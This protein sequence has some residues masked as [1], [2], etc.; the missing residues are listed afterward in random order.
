M[1]NLY[2]STKKTLF[3]KYVDNYPCLPKDPSYK[4]MRD[5]FLDMAG[6]NLEHMDILPPCTELRP[7]LTV[8]F[9]A[10][11]AEKCPKLVSANFG[12]DVVRKRFAFKYVEITYSRKLTA[13]LVQSFVH[14]TSSS[15]NKIQNQEY[16]YIDY[17]QELGLKGQVTT[18]KQVSQLRCSTI[19]NCEQRNL[20]LDGSELD[21]L[22]E[23]EA[24]MV[25]FLQDQVS[26]EFEF[27]YL[28]NHLGLKR[29]NILNS[30][31]TKYGDYHGMGMIR[32]VRFEFISKLA[33][34]CPDLKHFDINNQ[35]VWHHHDLTQANAR[36]INNIYLTDKVSSLQYVVAIIFLNA[37]HL[38]AKSN[39]ANV[40]LNL[41]YTKEVDG[42][43]HLIQLNITR[44]DVE[45]DSLDIQ[46]THK[47]VSLGQV[48]PVNQL[49]CKISEQ[50]IQNDFGVRETDLDFLK[51]FSEKLKIVLGFQVFHFS[52][53]EHHKNVTK[54]IV[55]N[56]D[57]QDEFDVM[58][59][60][61]NLA[62]TCYYPH[63]VDRNNLL[64]LI[65]FISCRGQHF[66]HLDV[67]FCQCKIDG[68]LIKELIAAIPDHAPNVESLTLSFHQIKG[69]ADCSS[70]FVKL[71][72]K[73]E[74]IRELRLAG[75]YIDQDAFEY[76]LWHCKSLRSISCKL[77]RTT[78]DSNT[79]K[80]S[81]DVTKQLVEARVAMR[82]SRL[83]KSPNVLYHYDN[84]KLY[85]TYMLFEM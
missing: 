70:Q 40:L 34:L 48:N 80:N 42:S 51:G 28:S 10:R 27:G 2:V 57:T 39:R 77:I 7:L 65:A 30:V 78:Y 60:D 54:L 1:V 59:C 11:L 3:L 68:N 58:A 45:K 15:R 83:K 38:S 6:C 44:N 24:S 56:R 12:G 74:K 49:L 79:L 29:L 46:Y 19:E 85:E 67:R 50:C 9:V 36:S 84:G 66:Q 16:L 81:L 23:C 47:L 76:A 14:T 62:S 18:Y 4:Q 13:E 63:N 17:E 75:L 43:I 64:G 41:S 35:I 26:P 20:V 25:I 22:K 37:V 5:I 8:E 33:Q 69:S 61:H 52:S 32:F 55:Y 53:I 72:T 73:L 82:D 21:V 71:F 31:R